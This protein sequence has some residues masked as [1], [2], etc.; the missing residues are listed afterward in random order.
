V[1]NHHFAWQ[2]VEACQSKPFKAKLFLYK[3]VK[4]GK[5]HIW[6]LLNMVLPFFYPKLGDESFLFL[7]VHNKYMAQ[8]IQEPREEQRGQYMEAGY[9]QAVNQVQS[10]VGPDAFE[11]GYDQNLAERVLQE[12]FRMAYSELRESNE[13]VRNANHA[14]DLILNRARNI[15]DDF[16]DGDRDFP[17]TDPSEPPLPVSDRD[18]PLFNAAHRLLSN[19]VELELAES[20]PRSTSPE[21]VNLGLARIREEAGRYVTRYVSME[22]QEET[23]GIITRTLS[24][25]ANNLRENYRLDAE[26]A[27]IDI[28]HDAEELLEDIAQGR[29]NTVSTFDDTTTT[30]YAGLHDEYE[31]NYED[32]SRA[33][34][35][36]HNIG[37][38]RNRNILDSVPRR[39]Q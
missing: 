31:N 24:L 17:S 36:L 33:W 25:A 27:A 23:Y 2:I 7:F 4:S 37:L 35:V 29:L 19:H 10:I 38:G 6:F 34:R 21:I 39:T 3:L 12:S 15:I 18:V 26:N 30:R 13:D 32:Y 1:N 28:R 20:Q 8:P 22:S 16:R 5:V 14:R 11:D 9:Q